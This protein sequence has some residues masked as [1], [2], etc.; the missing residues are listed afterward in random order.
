MFKKQGQ[1]GEGVSF[2]MLTSLGTQCS[3]SSLKAFYL[4]ILM[5]SLWFNPEAFRVTMFLGMKMAKQMLVFLFK[6]LKV[7]KVI[8]FFLD[9]C[10]PVLD[11]VQSALYA[12]R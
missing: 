3:V 9:D 4:L 6:A 5:R 12:L 11:A 7:H 10:V 8:K 1:I 2:H